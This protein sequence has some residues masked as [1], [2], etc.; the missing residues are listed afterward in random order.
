LTLAKIDQQFDSRDCDSSPINEHYML[1]Q[2]VGLQGTPAIV[3][4]DG[5]MVNGYVTAA[6]LSRIISLSD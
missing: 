4:E 2:D 1:G 5:T 3:L 6:E